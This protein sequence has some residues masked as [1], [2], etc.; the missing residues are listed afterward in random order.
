MIS[1]PVRCKRIED[2]IFHFSEVFFL[3]LLVDTTIYF[4]VYNRS[5]NI[6][7][8]IRTYRTLRDVW[9]GIG[10]ATRQRVHF[11]YR[12]SSAMRFTHPP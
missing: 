8:S 9:L 5:M 6:M 7:P 11:R 10:P 1:E 4:E 3:V 12:Y 2:T